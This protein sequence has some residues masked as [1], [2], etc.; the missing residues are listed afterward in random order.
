MAGLKLSQWKIP[1]FRHIVRIFLE[2]GQTVFRPAI[3]LFLDEMIGKIGRQPLCPVALLI[4]RK[5][6]VS[7]PVV[8]DLMGI[9]RME[10]KREADDLRSQ[11]GKRGHSKTRLPEVFH[12]GEFSVGIGTDELLVH[13]QVSNGCSKVSFGKLIV[14]RAQENLGFNSTVPGVAVFRKPCS[15]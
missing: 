10:D 9:G 7:P 12:K 4:L 15:D 13:G 6:A 8:K 1:D 11:E 5:D 3:P 14:R 2:N